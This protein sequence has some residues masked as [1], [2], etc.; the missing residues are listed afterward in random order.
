MESF[1]FFQSFYV[2]RHTDVSH[3]FEH[4]FSVFVYFMIGFWLLYKGKNS[5]SKEQGRKYIMFLCLFIF[6]LQVFKTCIRLYLGNFN[7]ATDIPL[8]VCNLMPLAMFFVFYLNSRALFGIFF[9]WIMCGTLQSNFTPTLWDHFPHYES[10]RYWATHAL[11][12]FIA[13]FGLVAMKWTLNYK[14]VIISWLS[15]TAGAYIMYHINNFLGAN[16]WFVNNKPKAATMYDLLGPW[17]DYMFQLFPIAWVLFTATFLIVKG[18]TVANQKW[19]SMQ[20]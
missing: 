8:Q 7:I 14:D 3:T 1:T 2:D 13:V 6:G 15:M 19:P 5:W 4:Y 10:I 18:I 17:P 11:L 16:Y 9:F 20:S 12:P